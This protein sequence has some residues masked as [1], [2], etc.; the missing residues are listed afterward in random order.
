MKDKTS[1]NPMPTTL[2][3]VDDP[4]E[5]ARSSVW[6]SLEVEKD[7]AR[8][9]NNGGGFFRGFDQN[10][11]KTSGEG[12]HLANQANPAAFCRSLSFHEVGEYGC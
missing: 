8:S 2:R 12:S 11:Y 6:G 10:Q 3:I 9:S 7:K 1:E 4:I 5:V